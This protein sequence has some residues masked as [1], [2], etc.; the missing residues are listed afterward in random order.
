MS[1]TITVP[2]TELW[3]PIKEEFI[4]IKEQTLVME[5]SLLSVD[6]WESKWRKPYLS[7]D[8]K[9]A[10]EVIDYL[11]CMTITKNVDPNVYFAIPEKELRRINEYITNPMTATTFNDRNERR[12]RREIITSEII[13]WQMTQLNIPMEWEKRHL[14]KLLTLIRVA[15]IKSQA[16]K[17]M[18]KADI[19]KQNR[20]LNAARRKR[21]GSKG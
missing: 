10:L 15:A 4:N 21:S 18:S 7:S 9:S 14:N 16:P 19:A 13:Y 11:R 5:H 12:G 6:K 3:D 17:Q 8:D 2:K 20:A 1:I